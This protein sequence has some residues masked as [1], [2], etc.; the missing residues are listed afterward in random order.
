MKDT[1]CE[2]CKHITHKKITVVYCLNLF[3]LLL[4]TELI[5]H[6]LYKM[7]YIIA[8]ISTNIKNT[9]LLNLI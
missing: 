7:V 6:K 2:K 4:T 8:S 3:P 9:I 1:L 5:L